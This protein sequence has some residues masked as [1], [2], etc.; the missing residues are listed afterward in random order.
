MKT[1]ELNINNQSI[2]RLTAIEYLM[3]T[4]QVN[5]SVD[6]SDICFRKDVADV[7]FVMLPKVVATLL[8]VIHGEETQ[9]NLIIS[10][11]T[12]ISMK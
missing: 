2:H 12:Q 6:F 9:G 4:F 8:K 10:V 7:M 3:T 1:I 5:D 11:G